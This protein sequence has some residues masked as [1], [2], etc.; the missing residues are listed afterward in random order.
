VIADPYWRERAACRTVPPDLFFA[1]DRQERPAT[2][3][4]REQSARMVCASCP[5]TALCLAWANTTGDMHSISGGLTPEERLAVQYSA[6]GRQQ[7]ANTRRAQKARQHRAALLDA[8][9]KTCT[10]PCGQT[11]PLDDFSTSKDFLRGDCKDCRNARYRRQRQETASID[12]ASADK[13]RE[14]A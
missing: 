7:S 8:G 6:A 4:M 12:D 9:V 5:V 3:E 2:R 14:T 10:G 1:P 11:K 13:E